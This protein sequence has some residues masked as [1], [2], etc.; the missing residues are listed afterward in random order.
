MHITIGLNKTHF[1]Y[2]NTLTTEQLGRARSKNAYI[3]I[4]PESDRNDVTNISLIDNKASIKGTCNKDDI[5]ILARVCACVS[6][7]AC[8]CARACACVCVGGGAC[9]RASVCVC[10]RMRVCVCVHGDI[11]RERERD[12][13]RKR[14]RERRT[15]QLQYQ[16][17]ITIICYVTMCV[18]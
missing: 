12:R 8:V 3:S 6:A 16:E 17:C 1:I 7:C 14:E 2:N 10:A 18:Y 4:R 5:N 13:E 11:Q 15:Y 9:V